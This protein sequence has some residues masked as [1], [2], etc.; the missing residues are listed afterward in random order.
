MASLISSLCY[1]GNQERRVRS[2]ERKSSGSAKTRKVKKVS[3]AIP[4]S[5][6]KLTPSNRQILLEAN[7]A[8]RFSFP[9]KA[10]K[11]TKKPRQVFKTALGKIAE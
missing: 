4:L 6:P 9:G 10:L 3:K 2:S 7:R 11:S 1:C 8:H 5:P